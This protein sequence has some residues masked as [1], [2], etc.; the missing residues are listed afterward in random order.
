MYLQ[1]SHYHDN[2]INIQ[3]YEEEYGKPGSTF[4][5]PVANGPKGV[6]KFVLKIIRGYHI[7]NKEVSSG[8]VV[9]MSIRAFLCVWGDY[10]VPCK[11]L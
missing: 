5:E 4:L 8:C 7:I 11:F 3:F 10:Q 6:D 9:G 2:D 1:G